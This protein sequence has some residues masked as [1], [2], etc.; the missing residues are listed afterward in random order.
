MEFLHVGV[1]TKNI[2][3][4]E[5]YVEALKV[6]ITNPDDHKFNFEYLRFEKGSPLPSIM[7]EQPHVA[8]KVDSIVEYAKD[9]EVIVEP[10]AAGDDMRLAFIVK[11]GVIFELMEVSK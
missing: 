5:T 1:P 10:F 9:A 2:H 6:H 3:P 4:N 8:I 11:D 7:Q